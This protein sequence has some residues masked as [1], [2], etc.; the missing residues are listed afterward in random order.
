MGHY[1][2]IQL[3]KFDSES[4]ITTDDFIDGQFS[5]FIRDGHADFVHYAHSPDDV[6]DMFEYKLWR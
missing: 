2:I 6:K 3:S 1:P 4:A 5:W